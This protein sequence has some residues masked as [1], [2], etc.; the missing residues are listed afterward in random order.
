MQ[1]YLSLCM[2]FSSDERLAE[3]LGEVRGGGIMTCK[4]AKEYE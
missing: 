4:Y 1:L 3:A 2:G